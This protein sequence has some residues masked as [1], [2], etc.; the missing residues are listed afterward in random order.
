M[1]EGETEQLEWLSNQI[2]KEIVDAN[3]ERVTSQSA[4]E[5]REPLLIGVIVALGGPVVIKSIVR[6]I[7][8]CLDHRER[9]KELEIQERSVELEHSSRKAEFAFKYIYNDDSEEIIDIIR[10]KSD[11]KQL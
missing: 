3:L 6:L 11:A 9:M 10:L 7:E 5:L 8:R 4:D 1:I 2:E